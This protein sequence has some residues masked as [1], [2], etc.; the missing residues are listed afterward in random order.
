MGSKGPDNSLNRTEIEKLD[1]LEAVA[2][3]GLATHA[4]VV[5][6]LT[7]IRDA[8]LYRE[9]HH[10]FE[11][12]LRE[13]WGIDAGPGSRPIDAP[14]V[15]DARSIR[16]VVGGGLLP[17]LRW[18]LAQSSGTIADVAHQVETRPFD[19][20]GHARAQLLDDIRVVEDELM[21]LGALLAPIDWD[22]EFERLL[23]DEIP[24][25]EIDA[26]SDE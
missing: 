2:Q 18:L 8:H 24:G 17:R 4:E 5:E 13:R 1:R 10:T 16:E 15:P 20:D 26:D 22:T 25:P 11:A 7:K 6:A 21:M 12:Y 3:R 9:T 23:R 14:H 19:L